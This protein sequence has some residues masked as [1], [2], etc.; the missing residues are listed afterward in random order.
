LTNY[1]NFQKDRRRLKDT[2]E[3]R[4]S[5]SDKRWYES[6]RKGREGLVL[7]TAADGKRIRS[8]SRPGLVRFRHPNDHGVGRKEARRCGIPTVG[9]A[10]SDCQYRERLTYAI[11]GNDESRVAQMTLMRRVKKVVEEAGK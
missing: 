11:P 10:D 4:K 1:T 9:V 2:Q 6:H 5:Y 7:K 8:K 3:E